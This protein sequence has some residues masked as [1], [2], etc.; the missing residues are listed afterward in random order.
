MAIKSLFL[1]YFFL[2]YKCS[3]RREIPKDEWDVERDVDYPMSDYDEIC[4]DLPYVLVMSPSLDFPQTPKSG[5]PP[6]FN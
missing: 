5:V 1:N 4:R 3:Y 6:Y 2:H